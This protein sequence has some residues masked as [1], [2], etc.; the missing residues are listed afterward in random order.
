[1]P[2]EDVDVGARIRVAEAARDAARFK[3]EQDAGFPSLKGTT[4][5]PKP[6]LVD[7]SNTSFVKNGDKMEQGEKINALS[8]YLNKAV[9]MTKDKTGKTIK[10]SKPKITNL[11]GID[12]RGNE[13]AYESEAYSSAYTPTGNFIDNMD[14]TVSIIVENKTGKT[15]GIKVLKTNFE[16]SVT[17]N[18]GNVSN[19]SNLGDEELI[20]TYVKKK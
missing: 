1:M 9:I 8:N 17:G 2:S 16:N 12:A 15:G 18:M 3:V 10:T 11:K 19:T 20:N 5:G 14:G 4:K 13:I 7:Y 6:S